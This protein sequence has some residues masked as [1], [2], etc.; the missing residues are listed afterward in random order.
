MIPNRKAIG[1]LLWSAFL[2]ISSSQSTPAGEFSKPTNTV[3]D[4]NCFGELQFTSH[5]GAIEFSRNEVYDFYYQY[6]SHSGHDSVHFG[7]GFFVP[8]LEATLIDHDYFL[9]VTTMGGATVYVYR[10]PADPDTYSSLNGRH[11]VFK[12][13]DDSY[14]RTTEDGFEFHYRLGKLIRM[15]TPKGTDVL[16]TYDGEYCKE[17]RSS[18]GAI[19]C[20]LTKTNETSALFS[21]ARGRYELAFQDHP[22]S[23]DPEY[24]AA[25]LPPLPTLKS[26]RWPNGEETAFSYPMDENSSEIVMHM[27][28]ADQTMECAWSRNSGRLIRADGVSY[29]ISP[30]S[31][32]VDYEAE[33][34]QTGVYSIRRDFPD[35][36]WKNFRHDEDGGFS[37]YEDS[38]GEHI[39]THFINTRGKV[40]NFVRK[41]ERIF[42]EEAPET[43]YEAFYDTEG[44]LIREINDDTVTW[45]L[46]PGGVP[47]T[48]VQP[49][50]NFM[51]L[52]EEGRV[53][54]ARLGD[55]TR[56]VQWLAN[57]S[58]RV[59]SRYTWGEVA[60]HYWDSNG[61]P[62]PFPSQEKFEE[63]R[64]FE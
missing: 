59:L 20:T 4:A 31:R 19:V 10:L 17:V 64:S 25:G 27:S 12:L 47:D 54:R 45:Y 16:F 41:R 26:I 63:R 37:E 1:A 53:V 43:F 57:G 49:G 9:E 5:V 38:D 50:D 29:E 48:V 33:R 55:E 24:K 61:N 35:G 15:Q 14:R 11:T 44:N 60:L 36:S 58:S 7:K 8:L 40:F 22:S 13:G 56:T 51:Q 30:L 21:T 39:R 46:R 42:P 23:N 28:Y 52:D 62:L 3:G 2:F 18:T 6:S 32:H 34:I